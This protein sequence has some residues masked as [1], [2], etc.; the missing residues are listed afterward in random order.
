VQFS[1]NLGL[2]NDIWP[3]VGE[4]LQLFPDIEQMTALFSRIIFKVIMSF[5]GH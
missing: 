5:S 4:L 3:A 2:L 1:I